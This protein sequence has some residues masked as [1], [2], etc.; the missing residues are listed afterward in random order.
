MYVCM[1]VTFSSNNSLIRFSTYCQRNFFGL[2]HVLATPG[3]RTG[4]LTDWF[5]V[6]QLH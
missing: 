5:D 1:Y 4:T 6:H 2:M 3:G